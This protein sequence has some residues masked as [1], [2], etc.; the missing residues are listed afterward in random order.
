M[1]ARLACYEPSRES[2][3]CSVIAWMGSRLN[4]AASASDRY[5]WY[6]FGY[7]CVFLAL[8]CCIGLHVPEIVILLLHIMLS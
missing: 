3:L 2:A 4:G 7:L 5:F 8:S 1:S 6:V